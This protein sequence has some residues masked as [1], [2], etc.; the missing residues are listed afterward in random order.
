MSP[1]GSLGGIQFSSIP[2]S[3]T[4]VIVRCLGGDGTVEDVH[5]RD[6]IGIYPLISDVCTLCICICHQLTDH[7]KNSLCSIVVTSL[8]AGD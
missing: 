1:L 2:S 3:N 7:C 5:V 8:T 6:V 4:L